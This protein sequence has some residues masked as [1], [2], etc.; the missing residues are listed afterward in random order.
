MC[1]LSSKLEK[2]ETH[3]DSLFQSESSQAV[4]GGSKEGHVQQCRLYLPDLDSL[5]QCTVLQDLSRCGRDLL[6]YCFSIVGTGIHPKPNTRVFLG[7][8]GGGG[9]GGRSDRRTKRR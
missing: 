2:I 5:G 7:G 8:G 1:S 9:G 4:C 3:G 6:Q